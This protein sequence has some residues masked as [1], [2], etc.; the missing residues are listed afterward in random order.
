MLTQCAQESEIRGAVRTAIFVVI[1]PI[2]C[3]G[4]RGVPVV[5]DPIVN[6]GLSDTACA[7]TSFEVDDHGTEFREVAIAA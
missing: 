4:P 5:K 7:S 3:V 2:I 1:G 6:I